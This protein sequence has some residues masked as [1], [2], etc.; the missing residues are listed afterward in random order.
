MT[1]K[2]LYDL[3]EDEQN[4]NHE[5]NGGRYSSNNPLSKLINS[6]VGHG[7]GDAFEQVIKD[8]E[9]D[10]RNFTDPIVGRGFGDV[11]ED[12][13]DD[14]LDP[15][16]SDSTAQPIIYSEWSP[17]ASYFGMDQATAYN[18]HMVNTA[19][20]RQVADLKAAGLNPVLGISGSGASGVSGSVSGASSGQKLFSGEAIADIIGA[21][22]S[23]VILAA[24]KNPYKGAM[25]ANAVSN[26]VSNFGKLY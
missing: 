3:S 11:L 23:V 4:R 14:I 10:I 8:N 5:G 26:A 2:R 6:V 20:Q 17:A 15:D 25:I 24:S 12:V 16:P 19:H 22:A 21:T 7:V 9:D 1:G 13:G 18:E